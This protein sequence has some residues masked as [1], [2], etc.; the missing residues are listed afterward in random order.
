M[1]VNNYLP[2]V[3]VLPEDDANRQVLN[4]FLLDPSLVDYRIRVLEEAG[5]WHETL[6]R[7]CSIYA[8]EMDRFPTRFMVLVIDFD[9]RA[10]RLNV[11]KAKIPQH[12]LDRVFVLGALKEPED[13]KRELG[14]YETIGLAMARDCREGTDTVWGHQQLRHNASEIGRLRL[15][16]R[17]ILFP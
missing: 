11:A 10:D 9:G 1:S 17:P 12:L 3:Y 15:L 8:D 13:L 7:F 4:G 2:H 5:G 6:D 14:S 16:V